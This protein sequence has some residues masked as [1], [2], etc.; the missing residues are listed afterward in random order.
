M[1]DLARSNSLTD[2]AARIN[3]EHEAASEALRRSLDH[4]ITAGTLLLEAKAQLSHGQWLPW[5]KTH[6]HV[7]E[8]TARLYM[9]LARNRAEIG[10]V[11]V[12]SV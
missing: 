8:R 12:F 1:K 4:A 2:L 3:T 9:R 11:A 7:P 10:N 6:C 5:L